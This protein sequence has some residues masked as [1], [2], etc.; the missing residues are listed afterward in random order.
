MKKRH[1][2]IPRVFKKSFSHAKKFILYKSYPNYPLITPKI[3][4]N[5]LL[6]LIKYLLYNFC[7]KNKKSGFKPKHVV[8]RL[9]NSTISTKNF[10][11]REQTKID[12][13][14][15]KRRIKKKKKWEQVFFE[16]SSCY[17]I[18]NEQLC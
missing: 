17:F 7:D 12:V 4:I 9:I 18:K 6:A 11:K 13:G 16:Y 5:I 10:Q 8:L 2:F 1:L 15:K 3:K 14:T